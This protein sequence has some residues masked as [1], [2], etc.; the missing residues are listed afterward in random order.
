MF[1]GVAAFAR[2]SG[3]RVLLTVGL[4]HYDPV[5]AAREVAAAHAALGPYLAAVEIGNEPDSYATHGL[6]DGS[7]GVGEYLSEVAAY[8]H[9]IA[10]ITPG[11]SIV[12]PDVS[13]SR[14]FQRWALPVA[15]A[16]HPALLTGHHYPLGCQDVPRP[17]DRPAAQ[18]GRCGGPR[19]RRSTA[20]SRLPTPPASPSA[21]TRPAACPAADGPASATPSPPHCGPSTSRSAP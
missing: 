18:P 19:A 3:W 20:T 12:A 21:S 4:A 1:R 14:A 5:V 17:V 15:A 8:R 10:A 6:R 7:W 2:R 11:V 13:G 16:A 9:A